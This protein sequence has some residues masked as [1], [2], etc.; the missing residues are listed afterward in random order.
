MSQDEF[1][2]A[3]NI[4]PDKVDFSQFHPLDHWPGTARCRGFYGGTRNHLSMAW[5]FKWRA[6][7]KHHTKCRLGLHEVVQAWRMGPNPATFTVCRNCSK[8]MS[9]PQPS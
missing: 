3:P 8:R 4:N 1:R 7:I 9:E 6:E 2:S 5:D